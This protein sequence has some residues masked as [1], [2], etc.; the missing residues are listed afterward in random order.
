MSDEDQKIEPLHRPAPEPTDAEGADPAA[1][2][3]AEDAAVDW[4]RP[5][6]WPQEVGGQRGPEP[7]RY[8]DWESH[9][10]CTDF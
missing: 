7:T 8:G 10:R 9:G 5:E 4:E 6:T 1:H 2:E 3:P